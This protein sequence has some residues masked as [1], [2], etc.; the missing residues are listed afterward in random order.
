MDAYQKLFFYCF[1]GI[2]IVFFL[3]PTFYFNAIQKFRFAGLYLVLIAN[4]SIFILSSTTG[5]ETGVFIFYLN[6]ML[7]TILVINSVDKLLIFGNFFITC[8]LI[9]ILE[10]T[11]HSLFLDQTL[12]VPNKLYLFYKVLFSSIAFMIF[13]IY[14]IVSIHTQIQDQF[15]QEERNLRSIFNFS[16]L[17]IALLDKET[18]LI[19]F[20]IHFKACMEHFSKIEIELGQE[21]INFFPDSE[22]I[23]F[24]NYFQ[25]A[26][27]GKIIHI[28][29][30]IKTEYTS[31]WFDFTFC[32]VL[33]G[34]DK[35]Q[36]IILTIINI[37]QRK[38]IEV[39]AQ[40]AKEKAEAAN[41]AKSHFIAN[42]S[43]EIR[44]PMNSIIGMSRILIDDNPSS[45]QK[46][47]LNIFKYSAEN[48]MI[49]LDDIL[50]FNKM[51]TGKLILDEV[52]FNLH[53]A[54]NSIR[55]LFKEQCQRNKIDFQFKIDPKLPTF[56]K[57]DSK[58]IMQIIS[59]LIN[60]AVKFTDS[61]E[62]IFEAL[63]KEINN[64]NVRIEFSI[65]D[66]G[67]GIS[68]DDQKVILET[69]HNRSKK[70]IEKRFK[71]IGL[72]IAITQ[73]LLELF[74]SELHLESKVGVGSK[75]FFE[76]NLTANEKYSDTIENT[77]SLNG[78]TVLIVDD[79]PVNQAVL[80]K[81][82]KLW[83]SQIDIADNGE[84]A[85]ELIK[86]K[87]YDMILM[88]LQMPELDGYQTAKIIRSWDEEKYRSVPII[89]VSATDFLDVK[90]K[91]YASGMNDY[92][93][94]PFYPEKLLQ[95]I[96]EHK[97][98]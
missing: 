31:N 24:E 62:I 13:G 21:I 30:N 96:L 95:K 64:S 78:L 93:S 50:D 53:L 1:L 38:N 39:E 18:K 66:T 60:N 90:D 6:T 36:N 88:D 59:N 27:K 16:Q 42:L 23:N 14:N 97:I 41:I 63:V 35:S 48:L 57:S 17:G 74:K 28:E 77:N 94:K 87:D 47:S 81:I 92:I 40:Y 20:N 33:E 5:R 70:E 51:E 10:L 65:S 49:L 86:A 76:L 15:L 34:E 43:H 71:G 54:L 4:T 84:K 44:T 68:K 8:I 29:K 37:T 2:L 7:I 46:N 75:F 85:L 56:V 55:D 26:G 25:L 72:G 79:N 89:A 9:I 3:A 69:F 98:I 61:G 82:L 52:E 58:R 22:K 80:A 45:D 67:I 12:S 73:K 19:S 91:L 32:P 11:D 83:N